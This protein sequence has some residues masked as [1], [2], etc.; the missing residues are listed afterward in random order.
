[1]IRSATVV[2]AYLMMKQN[3]TCKQVHLIHKKNENENKKF[4]GDPNS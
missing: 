3:M 1:M 4:A 2:I